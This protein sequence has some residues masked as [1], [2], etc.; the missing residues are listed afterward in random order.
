MIKKILIISSVIVLLLLIGIGGYSYLDKTIWLGE[1]KIPE[2]IATNRDIYGEQCPG[3][4]I[5]K[6]F[7]FQIHSS[8]SEYGFVLYQKMDESREVDIKE[9]N[10]IEVTKERENKVVQILTLNVGSS[11][12]GFG[13]TI[14]EN[15][16]EDE[17]FKAEDVNFDGYKDILLANM[18]MKNMNFNIWLFNKESNNFTYNKE[19]SAITNL[20]IDKEKEEITSAGSSGCMSMCGWYEKYRFENGK[21]VLIYEKVTD[22][23]EDG[24]SLM[25]ITRENRNGVMVEIKRET[26]P[27]P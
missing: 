3:Q 11:V 25:T 17:L 27:S 4:K 10:C 13:K 15:F 20:E 6:V 16:E 12:W 5:N 1:N 14:E 8:I 24:E 19:L 23:S 2:K 22:E 9:V 18:A 26:V 21:L 7:N